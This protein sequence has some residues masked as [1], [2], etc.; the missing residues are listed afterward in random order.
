MSFWLFFNFTGSKELP[1]LLIGVAG[2]IFLSVDV[3]SIVVVDSML[4]GD[5]IAV[6]FLIF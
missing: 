2:S 6:K 4:A 1:N 3:D 5:S